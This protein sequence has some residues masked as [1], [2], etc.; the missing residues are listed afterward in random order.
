MGIMTR[1]IGNQ[2]RRPS[3][4]IGKIFSRKMEKM[5]KQSSEWAI[6]LLQLQSADRVLEVGFGTGALIQMASK[7]VTEGHIS[8]LDFSAAM[9]EVASKRNSD[10]IDAGRV[11]LRN[12]DADNM[13]YTDG[14]FD[15]VYAI[16][17]IYLWPDLPRTLGELG[18]V[19]KVGGQLVL[20]VAPKTTMRQMGMDTLEFFTMHEAE[21]VASVVTKLGFS[22]VEIERADMH[23]GPA[24]CIVATK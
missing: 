8:G 18:R 21:D 19:L 11:E 9:L 22:E 10:A 16:N 2:A 3:G 6:E 13:P 15:K 1:I 4:I 17:V 7:Q 23:D 12:G 24:Q 14:S 5:T 20:Y